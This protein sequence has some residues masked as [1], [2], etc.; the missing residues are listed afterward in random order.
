M[1][2][3]IYCTFHALTPHTLR[4]LYTSLVRP[5]LNYACVVWQ[6]YLLKDIRKVEA[7]QR[8]ATRFLPNLAHLTYTD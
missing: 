4:F 1:I 2:G 3:I 5:I 8:R 7:V 6:S